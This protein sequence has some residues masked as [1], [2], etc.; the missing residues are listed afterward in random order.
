MCGLD[1]EAGRGYLF[2]SCLLVRMAEA[3]EGGLLLGVAGQCRTLEGVGRV[4]WE[5]V[6][7]ERVRRWACVGWVP[8]VGVAEES[9]SEAQTMAKKAR[10]DSWLRCCHATF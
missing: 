8:A 4:D 1:G 10:V 6:D 7:W 2:E 5:Q 3:V 9:A